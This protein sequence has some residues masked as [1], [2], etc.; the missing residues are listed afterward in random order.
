MKVARRPMRLAD[1][2]RFRQAAY[3]LFGA[4]LLS[5]DEER[6]RTLSAV[7]RQLEGESGRLDGFAFFPQWSRFVQALVKCQDSGAADLAEAY[8]RLFLIN[9]S[10]VCPPYASH[11]LAPEAPARV[12]AEVEEAY[13][14]AGL[15][16]SPSLNEPPDHVSVELEFM[17]LL[18]GEEAAAWR[19]R[20][21]GH[22]LQR[23]DSE[24]GFLDR[25]LLPWFPELSG[26]VAKQDGY[27]F[28][29][30]VTDAAGAFLAHDLD[31]IAAL[32]GRCREV[33]NR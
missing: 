17:G 21:L 12:M 3:R 33:A 28:Y 15:A 4:A 7:A 31:L 30:L 23:L 1:L 6:F 13:A 25:H 10:G 9:P 18:C 29:T 2:A 14:R 27:G 8:T 22:G 19:R 26:Q 24:A 20:K 5:P 32:R 11:Y 16:V